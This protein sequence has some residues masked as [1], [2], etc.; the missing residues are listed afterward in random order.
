MKSR[1]Q[2]VLR[3]S[4]KP[5]FLL[6]RRLVHTLGSGAYAVFMA[7]A[8]KRQRFERTARLGNRAAS[9]FDPL[10]S[11][12]TLRSRAAMQMGQTVN[13]LEYA[14]RGA[15][16]SPKSLSARGNLLGLA[17]RV[18][19]TDP[20][21]HPVVPTSMPAPTES[22]PSTVLYVAKESMPWQ[23]NG[24]CTRS[25]ETLL[26]ISKTGH[27]PIAIT[28]PGYPEKGAAASSIVEGI[29]YRHLLP[30][31]E[32]VLKLPYDTYLQLSTD[33][34][35]AQMQGIRPGLIHV[36]SG[37]R[38]YETAL[39]GAALS[40]WAQVPWVYEVRS[41]FETT[42]TSNERYME[43]S[44]YFERRLQSETRAMKQADL[45][46]TLSGP[47]RDVIIDVHGINP[48]RVVQLPNAVDLTRFEARERDVQLR[49]KLGLDGCFVLGYVSNLDHFREG[50]EVLLKG[51]AL[52]RK[53]GVNA[54]ALLVGD[55]RRRSELEAL[56]RKLGLGKH[57]VFTGNVPFDQVDDYY[58]QIDLFVVPRVNERAGRLVS[59][60][61]PFE[62]MAMGVPIMV[63]DLPALLEI[64][65]DNRC[66]VFRHED[67]S[68]LADVAAALHANPGQR[69]ELVKRARAWVTSERT[70]DANAR[71]IAAAY[72]QARINFQQRRRS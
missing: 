70:W 9:R 67:P 37:H 18:V 3:T 42:W 43:S 12:E 29:E 6:A 1:L 55:G 8:Y 53:R 17:G 60:M 58:A 52:L 34:F 66:A 20:R 45:V 62:A 64:A 50:Q 15:M 22:D 51:V 33:L 69:E 54:A 47:M 10:A 28:M 26:A 41:F 71:V 59:P 13:A 25:H 38:G 23:N 2:Q 65:E 19:E 36:G 30:G 35:A 56:A 57:A 32:S 40:R 31:S 11:T 14:T 16:A 39:M 72:E 61:K 27:T 44:E 63:S 7:A 24:Y 48:D 46:I 5:M 68:H 4:G 21:W 49:T